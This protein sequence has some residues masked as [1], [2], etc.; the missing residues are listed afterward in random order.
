MNILIQKMENILLTVIIFF[1]TICVLILIITVQYK[2]YNNFRKE[3]NNTIISQL[4]NQN[5]YDTN[6]NNLYNFT[7]VYKDKNYYLAS[8]ELN[9][10]CLTPQRFDC[11]KTIFILIEQVEYLKRNMLFKQNVNNISTKL[12]NKQYFG[13]F[14]IRKIKSSKCGDRYLIISTQSTIMTP[15]LYNEKNIEFVCGVNVNN[16]SLI[17][18]IYDKNNSQMF[19][20]TI[21]G[22]YIGVCVK[23]G[24][25]CFGII[26]DD[27]SNIC[28]KQ[29]MSV[30]L[31]N[32]KPRDYLRLC[33]YKNENDPNILLFN[34]QLNK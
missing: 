31:C 10:N 13:D 9:N 12:Q 22:L 23:D 27:V 33:F 19:K 8:I 5:N 17:T 30:D 1:I 2:I 6:Y 18:F 28:S 29:S 14:R 15:K 25:T 26:T 21:N 11:N 20:M 3:L 16:D 7:C 4:N 24:Q 32:Q 34:K